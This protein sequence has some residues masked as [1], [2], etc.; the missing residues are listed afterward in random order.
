[1]VARR[2]LS[3]EEIRGGTRLGRQQL[4]TGRT[5]V[6]RRRGTGGEAEQSCWGGSMRRWFCGLGRTALVLLMV[7]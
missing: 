2:C 3:T 5:R 1:M 4:G 7:I 6:R